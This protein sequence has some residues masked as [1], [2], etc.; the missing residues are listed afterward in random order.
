MKLNYDTILLRIKDAEQDPDYQKIS[1]YVCSVSGVNPLK[2]ASISSEESLHKYIDNLQC[3][4]LKV[5]PDDL[6]DNGTACG[7]VPNK[8]FNKDVVQY[9]KDQKVDYLWISISYDSTPPR[10]CYLILG[11]EVHLNSSKANKL[12]SLIGKAHGSW[13]PDVG[14]KRGWSS[15]ET[16]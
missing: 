9:L 3:P 1:E 7:G 2:L 13:R 6:L 15:F 4:I 10:E 12:S 16:E 5:T 14:H 11:S 8:C